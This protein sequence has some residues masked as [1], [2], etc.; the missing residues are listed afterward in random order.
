MIEGYGFVQLVIPLQ[1]LRACGLWRDLDVGSAREA[2]SLHAGRGHALGAAAGS[3]R[4]LAPS[5]QLRRSA[6]G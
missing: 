6:S 1:G 4:G 2:W 3:A 5:R